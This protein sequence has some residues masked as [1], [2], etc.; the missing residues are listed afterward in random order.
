MIRDD[1][2]QITLMNGKHKFI[3]RH[4]QG[5]TLDRFYKNYYPK[6][7]PSKKCQFA[8]NLI[9][10]NKELHKK[11]KFFLDCMPPNVV[12]SLKDLSCVIVDGIEKLDHQLLAADLIQPINQIYTFFTKAGFKSKGVEDALEKANRNKVSYDAFYNY[13]NKHLLKEENFGSVEALNL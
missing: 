9:N 6:L 8:I 3:T 5:E 7:T 11:G 13:I 1:I 2:S 12:V 10:A 4:I